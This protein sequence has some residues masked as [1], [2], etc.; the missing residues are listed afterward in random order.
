MSSPPAVKIGF[1]SPV[2]TSRPHFASFRSIIPD[3]V[4]MDFA[5]L[6][7]PIRA[8]TDFKDR[9]D[10]V[11]AATTSLTEQRGWDAVIVPGAPVELQNPGLRERL[12]DALAVPFTT[13]L[14]SCVESLKAVGAHRVLVLTPFDE[15]MNALLRTH[16]EEA[17]IEATCPDT[18]FGTE[19][20]AVGFG[21]EEVVTLTQGFIRAAG[22]VD[23]LYFQGAVLD[24]VPIIDRLES[25]LGMPVIASNPAMLWSILSKLGMR[26][27]LAGPGRLLATWPSLVG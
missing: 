23:A 17:G 10:K 14:A 13:A 19:D 25:E 18:G 22:E 3:D 9:A 4:Q 21:T 5:E 16:L 15:A 11:L 12:R 1:M 6:G 7:I 8:L 26:Y 2:T 27:D 24:A 20:N